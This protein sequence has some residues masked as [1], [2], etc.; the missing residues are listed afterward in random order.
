MPEGK[1]RECRCF[2]S[3]SRYMQGP[4]LVKRLP[5][6]AANFGPAA[7]LIIDP[8]LYDEFAESVPKMFEEAGMRAYAVKFPG[9]SGHKELAD[10]LEYVKTLPEV[11]DT[12]IGM[13][14]GQ[15]VDINKAV[16]AKLR[17][18]W[19]SFSTAL[20]TDAPTLSHT[21]INNPGA[22]NEIMFHYKNPDFVVVDTEVTI[23]APAWMLVSGI[24]DALATYFEAE[25][26]FKNN[27][28]CNSGLDDYRP[29]LLGLSTAKLCCDVLLKEGVAAVRAAN[30]HLRTPVYE[31]VVEAVTLLSGVGCENTG[32]SV[33][34]GLQA[35]FPAALP[36]HF[37]H[38]IGVGYCTLV[39]LVLE[40]HEMFEE[41]FE[42]CKAVGLP[43][44][45]ADLE[46]PADK[47]D[48]IV[49]ALVDEVYGR[50][51]QVTNVP[52][53]YE[54]SSLVD[55]IKYLDAYAEE[56]K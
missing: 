4:G 28:V 31:D 19:I 33:A 48:E 20:T 22:Q 36:K 3:P 26:S 43:V 40:N 34:H 27:N 15:T 37:P 39:Q 5:K 14:G 7:M 29:T 38:G 54:K 25:A 16:A 41:V 2:Q 35:A 17:K 44:C 49:Q 51:W 24:G 18:N 56:H 45:T 23:K 32:F 12:F 30:N 47:R 42:F 1:A 8:A 52:F 21:I 10:M 46:V 53:I 9:Y 11:P 55:S 6:F 50:R 13:G